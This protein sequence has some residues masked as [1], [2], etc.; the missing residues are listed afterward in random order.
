[1]G[2]NYNPL[3]AKG[4]GC[5]SLDYNISVW[6]KKKKEWI[7]Q[8][9]KLGL[10]VNAW[11]VNKEEDIRWCIQNG[12]DYITTDEPILVKKIIKEMC[13]AKK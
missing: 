8:A 2:N 11:T 4:L 1:M 7:K 10:T 3:Y 13:G 5:S 6:K 9:H 12:V